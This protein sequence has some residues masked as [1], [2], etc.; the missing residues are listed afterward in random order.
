M[1]RNSR[2]SISRRYHS[3][4][5]RSLSWRLRRR[6]RQKIPGKNPGSEKKHS[7]FVHGSDP[8]S[9]SLT[10]QILTNNNKKIFRQ[11]PCS[12]YF[13]SFH[14]LFLFYHLQHFL[15]TTKQNK[16]PLI[17]F[18][19]FQYSFVSTYYLKA[20]LRDIA[21]IWLHRWSSRIKQIRQALFCVETEDS[22]CQQRSNGNHSQFGAL[23]ALG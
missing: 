11:F 22:L 16:T 20:E 7:C 8:Y 10:N 23:K 15:A 1:W 17:S 13:F 3:P 12:L 21:S 14:G 6:S 2:T 4:S 9:C 18:S 19:K 5:R